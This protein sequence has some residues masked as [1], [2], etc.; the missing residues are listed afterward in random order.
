M[1]FNCLGNPDTFFHQGY[2]FM[3][4]LHH[5]LL[6]LPLLHSTRSTNAKSVQLVVSQPSADCAGQSLALMAEL[7]FQTLFVVSPRG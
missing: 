6:L 5:L 3:I 7:Q 4:H 1:K 2:E